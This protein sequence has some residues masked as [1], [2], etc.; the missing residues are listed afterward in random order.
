MNVHRYETQVHKDADKAHRAAQQSGYASDY[1]KA[2][3]LFEK[4]GDYGMAR[5]C[6]EAAERL[7]S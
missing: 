2:A 4:C 6:R 5:V 1:I 7:Q 3:E